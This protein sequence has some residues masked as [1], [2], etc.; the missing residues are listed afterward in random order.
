MTNNESQVKIGPKPIGTV[1]DDEE[2]DVDEVIGFLT[3]STTGEALVPREWLLDQWENYNLPN[4]LL[5]SS[6]SN[7]QAYRRMK[8]DLLEDTEYSHY[9]VYNDEYD[10][11]FNCKFELEKS[12]EMGSN[13]YIVYSKVFFP[14]EIIDE[15]GGDWRSTRVGRMEFFRPEDDMPGQLI[16]NFDEDG[17]GGMGTVHEDACKRLGDRAR[18]LFKKMQDHHNYSDLQKI[19]D[20]FRLDANAVA[21]RRAVHFIGSHHQDTVEGLSQLWED[22]N[23]W[24]DHGEEMRIETTPVINIE[25][26]R[27]MVAE[28]VKQKVNTLVDDIINETMQKFEDDDEMTAEATSREIMN[29]LA[30]TYDISEEYNSLLSLRLSIKDILEDQREEMKEE[31][32]EIVD[33]VI[34]QS[35]L[36]DY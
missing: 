2:D 25:S 15:E 31:Q 10:R 3:F 26:Q 36:E 23:D 14:E 6:I 19:I 27:E 7:W 8:N 22:M 16:T 12:D 18:E 28:R 21:I 1:Q 34:E 9:Q 33:S 30:E 17:D 29:Q 5:P 24:K 32:A 35:N 4:Y 13:T 11:H 20:D